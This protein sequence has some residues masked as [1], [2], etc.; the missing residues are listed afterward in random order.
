MEASWS[1]LEST[2]ADFRGLSSLQSASLRSQAEPANH[3][4]GAQSSLQSVPLRSQAEPAKHDTGVQSSQQSVPSRSL[5]EPAKHVSGVQSSRQSVPLRSLAEPSKGVAAVQSSRQ[6]VPLRSLAEPGLGLGF[7]SPHIRGLLLDMP[8]GRFVIS[9]VFPDLNAALSSAPGWL[10]L[11]SGSRGFAKALAA[12]SPCWILCLDISHREDE[13]L[14]RPSLQSLVLELIEAKTFAGV[15]GGPVCSSFFSAITPA[16]RTKEYSQGHPRLRQDQRD[17]VLAGNRMLEFTL[18]VVQAASRCGAVF[19]IETPQGSGFWRQPAWSRLPPDVEWGD[20]LCDFCRFGTKW[21]KATRFRTNGQMSGA[22]M[23]CT[24]DHSHLVLRGRERSSGVSWTKL[25]QPYPKRLSVLL[26]TA[27]AQDAGWLGNFRPLDLARYAKCG[28]GRI[29]EASHTRPRK[30][31]RRRA[32]IQLWEVDTVTK[33]T[34]VLRAGIWAGLRD[35]LDREAVRLVLRS[36]LLLRSSLTSLWKCCCPHGHVQVV[37]LPEPLAAEAALPR[38][39][40][41][42]CLIGPGHLSG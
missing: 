31:N 30:A 39:S 7:C 22:R 18:E 23:R 34:A 26:A 11:L 4:T 10:D 41:A 15:S 19:W 16:W 9:S 2:E 38:S 8:P 29:G 35:W 5:A 24:G 33:G 21:R 32:E 20:F 1:S 17:K 36:G 12:C 3:D 14:L 40:R 6:S 37:L 28:D 42:L 27:S 13:D 25:A